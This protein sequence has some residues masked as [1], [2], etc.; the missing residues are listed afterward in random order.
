MAL[1]LK[2]AHLKRYKDV[3]VLFLK[4][5]REDLVKDTGFEEAGEDVGQPVEAGKAEELAADLE[6]LGPTFIK[7]GQ[8]LSSR[9]E[10]LPEPW[11][12]ALSRLQDD[13]APFPYEE[14]ERIVSEELGIRISKGF[15][16]FDPKPVAAASLGQVHRAALRDGRLV[17][18]KVQRPGIRQQ[19]GEDLDALDEIAAVLEKRTRWGKQFQL[20]AMAEEFRKTLKAELDYRQEAQHL[21]K[22]GE[23]LRSFQRIVVPAPVDDYTSSRVLTMDLVQGQKVT[24][25]SPLSLLEVDGE[26]LADDL[27]HAYLKQ[28]FVDGFFHADPHPG[29]VFLT[30]DHRVALLDLGMVARVP[31]RLQEHLLQM[32]LAISE[33]KSDETADYA[34]KVGEATDQLNE[35]EFRRRV[36]E[37]VERHQDASLGELQ[38]GRTFLDMARFSAKPASCC[39]PR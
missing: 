16:F 10:L 8:L 1:A 6:R 34:L 22:L 31:P 30:E 2:P 14:V 19:I 15:A 25:L 21:V 12:D 3:A 39:R 38:V 17:V 18:V 32:V 26:E 29:N 20:V 5:G 11:L 36:T 24:S 23:N 33:G 27:F 35:K 37:L 7:L 4:Y 13:V 9:A 28:I